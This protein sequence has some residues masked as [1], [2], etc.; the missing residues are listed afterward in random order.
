MRAIGWRSTLLV[1]AGHH[2][3]HVSATSSSCEFAAV[4]LFETCMHTNEWWA[5]SAKSVVQLEYSR[6]RVME[7]I[8]LD[9]RATCHHELQRYKE[10]SSCTL[11]GDQAFVKNEC[12][13]ERMCTT[14]H[15]AI[16]NFY[17]IG[18]KIP[19]R[20]FKQGGGARGVQQQGPAR[21][22]IPVLCTSMSL[23]YTVYALLS[24]SVNID[25]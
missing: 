20:I 7:S 21:Y 9:G 6:P 3:L 13:V 1:F 10:N 15:T 18:W 24:S 16:T 5:C 17:N 11:D 12:D 4:F 19:A 23:D 2:L 14:R 8:S 25:A 22:I